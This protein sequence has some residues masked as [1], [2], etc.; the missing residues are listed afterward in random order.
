MSLINTL[1]NLIVGIVVGM[2]VFLIM[3]SPAFL[4]P[5]AWVRFFRQGGQWQQSGWRR[6]TGLLN[7]IAVSGLL[8]VFVVKVLGTHCNTAVGDWSCVSAWRSFATVVVRSTPAFLT[9]A[10]VGAKGT[11]ILT[12][13]SAVAICLDCMYIAALA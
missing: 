11:R 5:L 8:I 7:L 6:I 1:R 10:F 3:L 4:I 2:P 12:G 13:V 9:L